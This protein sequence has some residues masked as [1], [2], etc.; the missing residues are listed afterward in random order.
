MVDIESLI[1]TKES[2][3]TFLSTQ[4]VN[5]QKKQCGGVFLTIWLC[6]LNADSTKT[7]SSNVTF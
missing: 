5:L 1:S 2:E 7:H 4:P 6:I 3:K